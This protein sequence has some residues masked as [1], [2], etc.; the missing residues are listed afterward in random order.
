MRLVRGVA[1][2]CYAQIDPRRLS[3]SRPRVGRD[4]RFRLLLQRSAVRGP[5]PSRAQNARWLQPTRID[6][7][8]ELP[9]G[10]E[11]SPLLH[12]TIAAPVRNVLAW[13]Q[14]ETQS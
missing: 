9:A 2:E 4:V 7:N 14:D 13:T 5:C 6:P 1:C 3:A 10:A 8:R 12:P 11:Q